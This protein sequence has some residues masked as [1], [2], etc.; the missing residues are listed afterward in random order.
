MKNSRIVF[1]LILCALFFN[2][3]TPNEIIEETNLTNIQDDFQLRDG[4]TG[5]DDKE[6]DE[7]E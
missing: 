4:D 7:P 5:D 2:S 3:C 1:A 6:V